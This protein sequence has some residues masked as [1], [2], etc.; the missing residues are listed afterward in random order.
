[1]H[2]AEKILK[3][4]GFASWTDAEQRALASMMRNIVKCESTEGIVN[5]TDRVCTTAILLL[6]SH[7]PTPTTTIDEVV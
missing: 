5:R 6:D 1:M 3:D 2:P 7:L 4:V